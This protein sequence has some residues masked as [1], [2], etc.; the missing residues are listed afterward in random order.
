MCFVVGHYNPVDSGHCGIVDFDGWGI[1]AGAN[2]V[3]RLFPEW[4]VT[5]GYNTYNGLIDE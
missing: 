3:N 4:E 2:T 5:C 1:A